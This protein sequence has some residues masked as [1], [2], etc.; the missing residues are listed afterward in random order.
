MER[1]MTPDEYK[2]RLIKKLNALIAILEVAIRKVERS[3]DLPTAK[4]SERLMQTCVNLRNTL[5]ICQRAK[6]NLEKSRPRVA[7]PSGAREYIEMSNLDEYRKF[8]NLPPITK[9]DIKMVDM[10]E[11]T[12]K[13]QNDNT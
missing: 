13:F 12:R 1:P 10:F 6:N 8:Q 11:L 9:E 7:G 2:A 5:A 3:I 4:N